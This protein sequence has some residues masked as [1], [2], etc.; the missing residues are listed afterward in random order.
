MSK[1]S[2]P[3]PVGFRLSA[4]RDYYANFTPGSGMAAA[5]THERLTL[6]FRLDGTFAGPVTCLVTSP[7][8]SRDR[9]RVLMPA[10][11][12]VLGAAAP[13]QVRTGGRPRGTRL[14]QRT[15]H[16]SRSPHGC[17]KC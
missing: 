7:V 1:I 11:A 9:Q 8:Y 3:K 12:R 13:V 15:A 10:G 4:A 14:A 16:Q 6:A 17:H 5:D 2:L